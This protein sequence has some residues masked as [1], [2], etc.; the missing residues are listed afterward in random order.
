MPMRATS[1]HPI[2]WH[3]RGNPSPVSG[4]FVDTGL[5]HN[6]FVYHLLPWPYAKMI[7]DHGRLRFVRVDTWN[8]PFEK[9]WCEIL[10]P[11]STLG[12]R[13]RAYG[14]CWT[15]SRFDEPFWRMA[16]FQRHAPIVRLR[17]RALSL[18][19]A[20]MKDLSG[21]VGSLYLGVVRY[22]PHRQLLELARSATSEIDSV[23]S[24]SAASLLLHKRN[25][26]SFEKEVRLLWIDSANGADTKLVQIPSRDIVQ[27]VMI[28]PYTGFPTV[29]SIKNCVHRLGIECKQ[30]AIMRP[31]RFP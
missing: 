26:F 22:R 4:M 31:P 11:S 6:P 28:S 20:C 10:F 25:A 16:G 8:D 2:A 23:D 30:S 13:P 18:F 9:W 1:P 15:T 24:D 5:L 12:R 21:Q 17:C 3:T 27:Q 19:D 14:M 29:W 7:L